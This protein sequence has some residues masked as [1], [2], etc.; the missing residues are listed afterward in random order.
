M[1]GIRVWDGWAGIYGVRAITGYRADS[2]NGMCPNRLMGLVLG[3]STTQ[4]NASDHAGP[5][6]IEVMLRS[7]QK[8]TGGSSGHLFPSVFECNGKGWLR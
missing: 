3:R 2:L 1:S 6:T 8:N 4:H 5:I 7:W